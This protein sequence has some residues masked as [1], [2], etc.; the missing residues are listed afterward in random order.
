MTDATTS[1]MAAF[2]KEYLAGAQS[3]YLPSIPKHSRSTKTNTS[4]QK[5]Y[6]CITVPS[7]IPEAILLAAWASLLGSHTLAD[8]ITFGM[9]LA[10]TSSQSL[11]TSTVLPLRVSLG[12]NDS[13]EQIIEHVENSMKRIKG[14][15]GLKL[16]QIQDL[17]R[18]LQTACD[19]GSVLH[20]R[21]SHQSGSGEAVSEA[22]REH[23]TNTEAEFRD[24]APVSVDC[25][26][27]D[28][29]TKVTLQIQGELHAKD[30]AWE[31]L[32]QYI[33]CVSRLHK[34][35][36]VVDQVRVLRK[37]GNDL[38][39]SWTRECE[40]V[41]EHQLL[42][43]GI[44]KQ[45]RLNPLAVAVGETESV[46]MYQEL[47]MGANLL[48]RTLLNDTDKQE[49]R[50][51][52]VGV[53]FEKSSYAIMSMLAIL[54]AGK[55]YVPL[56]VDWPEQRIAY[57][58]KD[59]RITT[60]LCSKAKQ[61]LFKHDSIKATVVD[62][63]FMDDLRAD[64]PSAPQS[65]LEDGT[66][67]KPTDAAYILYTS[68]S[69][70]KPKGISISHQAIMT[71]VTAMAR[72]FNINNKTRTF[73][74]TTFTFDLSV[75]DI[76][77]TLNYGG[78]ICLPSEE[79]RLSPGDFLVQEHCNYTMTTPSLALTVEPEV[80]K[81]NLEVL[82]L[83]GES[84]PEKLLQNLATPDTSKF[85]V[86]NTWGPT[87]ACVIASSSGDIRREDESSISEPAD[88]IG[89]AVGA[90]IFIVSPTNPHELAPAFAPGEI[91]LVGNSLATCYYGNEAKTAEAFR[92]DLEWTK[93]KK[94]SQ[95]VG[96]EE[97][98]KRVYL[99]GDIGRYSERSD[100]SVIFMNRKEG[101]YVKVNGYRIDPGEVENSIS[102]VSEGGISQ[103]G[104]CIVV[105]E[106]S[107]DSS[108]DTNEPR[109]V[110]VCFFVEG[111]GRGAPANACKVFEY[112]E[113]TKAAVKK[114]TESLQETVPEYMIP[115]LFVP[116]DSMPT[117]SSHKIDRKYLQGMLGE[118]TWQQLV[119]RYGS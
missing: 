37:S 75:A 98:L 88:C 89:Y 63:D 92:T 82:S 59:A 65:S 48:A 107:S 104:I 119:E 3:T 5:T 43:V 14:H 76:W 45:S 46:M 108:D 80:W 85:G 8:D 79:E 36:D 72:F 111:D 33:E 78:R 99:T 117:S 4:V 110:L 35:Q 81:D 54:K 42:H 68:G 26:H 116:L 20:V 11:E 15:M 69:T 94:W 6:E 2:W 21:V 10:S 67:I 118:M 16:A 90:S 30:L 100:G 47:S 38:L 105:R 13:A 74:H 57:V 109:Q 32:L 60:V 58:I 29:T 24:V 97:A 102:R 91:A 95:V 84:V 71:S 96:G 53:C 28:G 49:G 55:A 87:E 19:F 112:R 7:V 17:D 39:T 64:S 52:N 73:Q 40:P 1:D 12:E 23:G 51:G 86:R 44:E 25:E 34:Q 103:K 115:R 106:R 101:G 113:E 22:A 18:S 61:S 50:S 56:D 41:P 70:G 66:E 9:I 77:M 62:D 31:L 93:D 83:I 27:I 114:V